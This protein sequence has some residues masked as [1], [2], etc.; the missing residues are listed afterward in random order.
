MLDSKTIRSL[1]GVFRP[2]FLTAEYLAGRRRPYLGPIRIYLVAAAIFFLAAP[3][4]GFTL[5]ALTARPGMER[6]DEAATERREALGMDARHF[7]E[8]FDLRLQAVYTAML[9]VSVVGA[10]PYSRCF[11][12]VGAIPSACTSYLRC[13]TWRFSTWPRS[14]SS[15]RRP[16]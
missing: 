14:W 15:A 3:M 7:A 5:D 9:G 2:G 12:A 10:Q 16:I 11:I 13:T 8:R 4:A 1:A 6:L